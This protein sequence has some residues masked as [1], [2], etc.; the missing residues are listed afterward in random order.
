MNTEIQTIIDSS[1][2]II[3]KK[4]HIIVFF[5]KTMIAGP[6][7]DA[8]LQ[9]VKSL[10]TGLVLILQK[11]KKIQIPLEAKYPCV[12]LIIIDDETDQIRRELIEENFLFLPSKIKKLRKED[13]FLYAHLLVEKNKDF[14][15]SY[16]GEILNTKKFLYGE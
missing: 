14:K 7:I 5:K 12:G 4:T 8:V 10:T 1:K 6:G 2:K 9:S 11:N 3:I 15:I 16:K 13:A